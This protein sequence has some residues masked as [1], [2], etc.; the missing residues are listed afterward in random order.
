LI[1][2]GADRQAVGNV[3]APWT[4]DTA[5]NLDI[6]AGPGKPDHAQSLSILNAGEQALQ[7][8][9]GSTIPIDSTADVKGWSFGTTPAGGKQAVVISAPNGIQ[10]LVATL[11]WNVTQTTNGVTMDT[12]DA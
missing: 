10:N 3:V 1:M 11:N 5:N 4:R 7:T 9:T 6:D 12:S 2:T 8:V